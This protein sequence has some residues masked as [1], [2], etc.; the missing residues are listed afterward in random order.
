MLRLWRLLIFVKLALLLEE[1]LCL[2]DHKVES[3]LL[4]FEDC[5]KLMKESRSNH[6]QG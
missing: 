6:K 2:E 3:L 1:H 5:K 4:D